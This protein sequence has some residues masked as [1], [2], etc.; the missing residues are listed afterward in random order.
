M[1]AFL[2]T[3]AGQ[4]ALVVAG[5]LIAFLLIAYHQLSFSYGPPSKLL[6]IAPAVALSGINIMLLSPGRDVHW[7]KAAV[8]LLAA[9]LMG[10]FV[11]VIAAIV[12]GIDPER[13]HSDFFRREVLGWTMGFFIVMVISTACSLFFACVTWIGNKLARS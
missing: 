8:V 12:L 10:A 6:L 5:G 2:N 11:V 9:S 4:K 1:K 13:I 3:Y 7:V